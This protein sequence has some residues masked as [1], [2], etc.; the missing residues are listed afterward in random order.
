MWNDNFLTACC[1]LQ[2]NKTKRVVG[3]ITIQSL[4]FSTPRTVVKSPSDHSSAVPPAA[5]TSSTSTVCTVPGFTRAKSSR[6][7]QAAVKADTIVSSICC[8]AANRSRITLSG[9]LGT[10]FVS[11]SLLSSPATM[12]CCPYSRISSWTAA[13][14]SAAV[15]CISVFV[16]SVVSKLPGGVKARAKCP[17]GSTVTGIRHRNFVL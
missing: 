15:S 10:C 11:P 5:I 7:E 4:S 16:S 12:G 6:R 3:F 13:V 17:D 1:F 14:I 9:T 2:N 8:A